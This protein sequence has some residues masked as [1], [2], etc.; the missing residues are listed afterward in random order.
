[1]AI[2][3]KISFFLA[4]FC[5]CKYWHAFC[6]Q[7]GGGLRKHTGTSDMQ[8][9]KETPRPPPPVFLTERLFEELV[10][11]WHQNQTI[12]EN[13][14]LI[15]E[16]SIFPLALPMKALNEFR[17]GRWRECLNFCYGLYQYQPV[18]PNHF[19]GLMADSA[20]RCGRHWEMSWP[21]LQFATMTKWA[22]SSFQILLNS[23]FPLR[24]VA[25]IFFG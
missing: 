3:V 22:L 18:L 9:A 17:M 21:F 20:Q 6:E 12:P 25:P 15:T 2:C 7:A 5:H 8:Q 4:Y 13:L 16:Q 11:L 10:T 1:M 19:I 23:T 14:M 24:K